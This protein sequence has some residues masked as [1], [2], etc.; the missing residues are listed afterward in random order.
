MPVRASPGHLAATGAAVA[1]L[2]LGA[3]VVQLTGAAESVRYEHPT[4]ARGAEVDQ[5]YLRTK[6]LDVA[7]RVRAAGAFGVRQRA[8][9]V[10]LETTNTD[11]RTVSLT[12]VTDALVL[13]HPDNWKPQ[14]QRAWAH[15]QGGGG[16]QLL[17]PGRRTTV[18]L[19]FN[20][21]DG[22]PPPRIGVVLI[23]FEN[24]PDFFHGHRVWT[25]VIDEEHGIPDDKGKPAHGVAAVVTLP[26]RTAR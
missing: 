25:E 2:A 24:R 17:Q 10:S 16:T 26:V 5:G 13:K 7:V 8:L 6:V 19:A 15:A 18:T 11:T 9:E 14:P 21:P 12:R 1:V 23:E 22:P 20:I 3:A 4:A